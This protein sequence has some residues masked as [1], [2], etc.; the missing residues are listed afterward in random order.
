MLSSSGILTPTARSSRGTSTAAV[1]PPLATILEKP[2]GS[3]A[4]I[5]CGPAR[6]PLAVSVLLVIALRCAL[7]GT[8]ADEIG[9]QT[10]KRNNLVSELLEASSISGPSKA[11]MFTRPMDGWIFIS[12]SSAGKGM[13]RVLLDSK[14]HRDEALVLDGENTSRAEAMRLVTRG[15]HALEI[16]CT[17]DIR[18]E[19]L[20]VK[21]IPELI[22]CGLGFNPEI[23]SY[24]LYDLEFLKKDILPNVTTLIV[25]NNINL[26]ESQ[27]ESWHRQ[28]KKFVAEIGIDSTARTSEEHFKFWT[29]FY[30]KT[31]F[32]DGV[33]I[34][35][36]IVNRPV[37]EWVAR[38]TPERLARMENE[39]QQYAAYGGAI[40]SMRADERY[41]N[42]ML[43]AYVGGSGK[44]LNQEII[45]TN[46]VR[47]IINCGYRVALE[48]YLHE[49]SSEQGSR[50]ALQTFVE[51]IAD[52]EAKEPGVKR[53]MVIAFGLFSMPPGGINKQPNVDYHVWMDQ[54]MNRVANDPGLSNIAGLEWW[55]SSLADEEAVRFVGKLYR[56]YAIE[57]KTEM[58]TRDPL[59]LTHLQ[60][61]DFEKGT[62]DWTL[63]PAQ[64]GSIAAK[65]F[66][67]YGRIEG[68]YMGLGRPA[69]PEHI[70]D[71]FLWMK[72]NEKGPNT[73]SQIIRDLEPGRLYSMKMF[74]CDYNDLVSPKIKKLEEAN[75]FIGSVVLENVDLDAK[76]SFKEMYSSNPEPKIP[77]WITYHWKVF[78]AKTKAAKL[79]VSDW[80]SVDQPGLGFGQEQTFN[81]VELQPYHE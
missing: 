56:H 47:T 7:S 63:Y 78:R 41:K 72:R 14:T 23:K 1:R 76:R 21:A 54:Q 26:A 15:E 50:D 33:I 69:D 13:A 62:N 40:K 19:H 20:L 37:S 77:V 74:T 61:A 34:D 28:G 4:R 5:C 71:T 12:V 44:K 55:T 52:W 75:Q 31:P 36:F 16:Q 38:M 81:F 65:S 17:G 58:L 67:R 8:S 25:P 60:N 42:K 66:P 9:F 43:Y 39:R 2:N 11:L 68:R 73:F 51:G 57:G 48:R 59:F 45:G 35:E 18:V 3:H 79:I 30:E 46:F 32:L 6:T 53:Q 70:G 29:G 27:I 49:M 22:H 10:K 24:G 80:P 64:E